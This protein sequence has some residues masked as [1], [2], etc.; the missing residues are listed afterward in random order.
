MCTVIEEKDVSL[1]TLSLALEQAVIRHDLDEEEQK[2]YITETA[3]FPFWIHVRR[4][5]GLVVLNTNT[6]FRSHV[7]TVQRLELANEFNGTYSLISACVDDAHLLVDYA[8]LYRDGL[9]RESF[10]RA[11]RIFSDNV[12]RAISELD[13]DD[14]L[15]LEPGESEVNEEEQVQDKQ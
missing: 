9:T 14:T 7:N 3:W 13:P 1:V 8:L 4:G 2:I 6:K 15:L 5:P 12:S 10:I 11:C